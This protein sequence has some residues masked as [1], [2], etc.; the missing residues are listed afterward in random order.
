VTQRFRAFYSKA[1][2]SIDYLTKVKKLMDNTLETKN[3]A[4]SIIY[5]L[6]VK[7]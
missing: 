3:K 5:A 2:S 7:K 1:L 4:I 6:S